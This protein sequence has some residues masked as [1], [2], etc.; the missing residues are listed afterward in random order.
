MYK[1]PYVALLVIVLQSWPKKQPGR[2]FDRT[3]AVFFST[4]LAVIRLS[5][6]TLSGKD[7]GKSRRTKNLPF[8]FKME[9]VIRRGLRFS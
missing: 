6:F 9:S 8:E 1:P 7:F 4:T 3:G 2:R 5:D